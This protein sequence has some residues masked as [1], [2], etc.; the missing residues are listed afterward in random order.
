M[1]KRLIQ[2]YQD[3]PRLKQVLALFSV[4]MLTIPLSFVSNIIITRFLGPIGFGDFKFV[5]YIFNFSLVLFSFGFFQA[6]NRALVLNKDPEKSREYYGSMLVILAGL[7]CNYGHFIIGI[8]FCRQKSPG[9]GPANY[10]DLHYPIL[11]AI[12]S[13]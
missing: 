7:F 4:N 12:P 13:D 5:L 3:N 8:F 1:I 11:M 9:E 10:T 2:L 6:G